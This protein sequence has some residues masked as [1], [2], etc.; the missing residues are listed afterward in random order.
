MTQVSYITGPSHVL[1][2]I[3]FVLTPNDI[4]MIKRPAVGTCQHGSVDEDKLIATIKEVISTLN[5]TQP[6]TL[7]P[8]RIA[9]VENDSSR[10]DLY[11]ICTQLLY[12]QFLS[13]PSLNGC[14]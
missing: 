12:Q 7:F 2:A 9:Y 10:L 14:E 3:E 13:K 11:A 1:L 6:I 5:K 8:A 4:I